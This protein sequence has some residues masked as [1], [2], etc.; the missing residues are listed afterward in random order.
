VRPSAHLGQNFLVDRSVLQAIADEVAKAHPKTI[1]E[2]GAGLGTV[3]RA[4]ASLAD[5]VVAV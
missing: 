5:R 3:T 1:L 2:I 4:L